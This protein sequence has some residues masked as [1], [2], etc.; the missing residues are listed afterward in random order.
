MK[1]KRRTPKRYRRDRGQARPHPPRRAP[2]SP[3]TEVVTVTF[4]Y[5]RPKGSTSTVR[6]FVVQ[7]DRPRR[8]LLQQLRDVARKVTEELARP[9][10]GPRL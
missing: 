8:E 2:T 9:V 4:E 7:L 6:S 1:A 5:T 10:R 3:L